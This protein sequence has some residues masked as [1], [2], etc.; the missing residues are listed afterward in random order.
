M[1]TACGSIPDADRI[2]GLSAKIYAI[3][4]NVVRPAT[5]SVFT[6]VLF[7]LSL[8]IFSNILSSS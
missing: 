4:M 8:N 3:V 1:S 6:V 5:T 2:A 7:S